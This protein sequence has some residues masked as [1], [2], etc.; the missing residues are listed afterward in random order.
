MP[1]YTHL[2]S[3]DQ[4]EKEMKYVYIYPVNGFKYYANIDQE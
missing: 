3:F 2:D 4:T 1:F